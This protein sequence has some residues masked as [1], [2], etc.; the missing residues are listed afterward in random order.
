MDKQSLIHLFDYHYWANERLWQSIAALSEEQYTGADGD[1]GPSVRALCVRMVATE[2]LWINYLWH[3]GVEFLDETHLPTRA[4]LRE[5][6][7]ALEEEIRDFLD[8]LSPADLNRRVT[9]PFLKP[10]ASLKVWEA[11]LQVINH[12]TETRA[13]VRLRLD[14]IGTTTAVQ[15][16][17]SFVTGAAAISKSEYVAS[18]GW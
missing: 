5:E 16:S 12:G 7:K 9:P 6:W 3:G 8:E 14:R 15:D 18:P 17:L 10:E 13:Q 11:L 1:G 4:L 2:N